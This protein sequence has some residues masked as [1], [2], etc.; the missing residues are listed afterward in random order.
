MLRNFGIILN[1]MQNDILIDQDEYKEKNAMLFDLE[2]LYYLVDERNA[3]LEFYQKLFEVLHVNYDK[4]YEAITIL[5]KY[6][7]STLND[8]PQIVNSLNL[9]NTFLNQIAKEIESL[10]KTLEKLQQDYLNKKRQYYN[11]LNIFD[12]DGFRDGLTIDEVNSFIEFLRTTKIDVKVIDEF[13]R[14]C[15]NN[16]GT[17]KEEDNIIDI[18][19]TLESTDIEFLTE[20]EKKLIEN[21]IENYNNLSEEE[22]NVIASA[23]FLINDNKDD[24][25]NDLSKALN[26]NEIMYYVEILKLKQ[27]YEAYVEK[28]KFDTS[29]LEDK[30]LVAVLKEETI[31]FREQLNTILANINDYL[32]LLE[33]QDEEV[34]E[35]LQ[36][37]NLLLFLDANEYLDEEI[38][39]TKNYLQEDIDNINNKVGGDTDKVL[40]Q[41]LRVIN[42]QLLS[43]T[44]N[45]LHG[46]GASQNKRLIEAYNENFPY[47]KEFNIRVCKGRVNNPARITYLTIPLSE[48]NRKE[49]VNKYYLN[50]QAY[51]YLILGIFNKSNSNTLYTYITHNRI[52]HEYESI[53]K[54]QKI[55]SEDFTNET[56]GIAYKLIDESKN[57]LDNL[58]DNYSH[59]REVVL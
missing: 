1:Y 25:I 17:E 43:M 40:R 32:S 56:R 58:E 59:K 41:I 24:Y 2:N 19:E 28:N 36:S 3:D 22:K 13:E 8:E 4:L 54:L 38:L 6:E 10:Q 47:F 18:E 49:L 7:K 11:Y 46:L 37:N 30:E 51:I 23:Q 5:N 34:E 16:I 50:N 55:F 14:Y 26:K 20:E 31:E 15:I 48:N 9:V 57:I 53:L 39:E 35:L 45:E 52:Q 33:H 27:L 29:D 42:T 21:Y 44:A 12:G